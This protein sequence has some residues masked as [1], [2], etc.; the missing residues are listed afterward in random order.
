MVISVRKI[1]LI[2]L[3][4]A[5]IFI[6]NQYNVDAMI[7]NYKCQKEISLK[8]I[9]L[10]NI[11]EYL[12]SVDKTIIKLCID[13]YCGFYKYKNKDQ[14]LTSY[15]N[16]Y[17]IYLNDNFDEEVAANQLNRNIYFTKMIVY[18]C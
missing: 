2:I 15:L 6:L 8:D 5:L 17:Y 3:L 18:E 9:N 4:L 10:N 12:K 11:K 16:N 7:K 1:L 14:S 13:E